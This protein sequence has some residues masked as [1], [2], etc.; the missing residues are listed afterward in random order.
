MVNTVQMQDGK[1]LMFK[2]L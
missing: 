1:V 2:S